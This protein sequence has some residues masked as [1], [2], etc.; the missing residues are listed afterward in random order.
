MSKGLYTVIENDVIL[1][2]GFSCGHGCV[3]E[4][5]VIVGDDVRLGH[6]V[7]LKSGT[8]FGDNIDF[9]DYCCTTG[10]CYVGNNVAVRTRSTISKGVIV[11]DDVFIGANVM[12]SHTKNIYHRRSGVCRKQLVTHICP[13]AIIGSCTNL[14]A[15]ITLGQNVVIGYGSLVVKDL[16]EP[17][18]YFGHPAK[19]IMELSDEMV[20]E[21]LPNWEPYE[22][23][24]AM[25][26]KYLPYA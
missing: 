15:G 4:S 3:I 11:E 2:K 21:R 7:V 6:N 19:F 23:S 10:I 14:V 18:I 20:M 9:A 5:D 24:E 25:L 26:E 22:F 12:T 8:R 16:L 13:G 17:G 1:G